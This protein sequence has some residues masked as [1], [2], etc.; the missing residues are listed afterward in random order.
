[1]KYLQKGIFDYLIN[2]EIP[3]LE[4]KEIIIS[5]QRRGIRKK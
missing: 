3:N 1:M 2:Q 5:N 4:N